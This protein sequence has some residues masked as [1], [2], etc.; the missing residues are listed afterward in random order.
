ML[1]GNKVII[2]VA[3]NGGMQ[4]SR[5]G[6]FVP[7]Q[8]LEIAEAAARCHEAGASVVHVHARDGEGRNSGDAAIYADIIRRAGASER[9]KTAGWPAA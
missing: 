4:P 9:V 7:T 3:V 8:P 6:A 5:D 2:T 1:E